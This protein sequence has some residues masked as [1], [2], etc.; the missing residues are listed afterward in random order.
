LNRGRDVNGVKQEDRIE[1][2]GFKVVLL[3]H[4]PCLE[5][6]LRSTRDIGSRFLG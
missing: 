1:V 6:N 2:R 4:D 5:V 3:Y